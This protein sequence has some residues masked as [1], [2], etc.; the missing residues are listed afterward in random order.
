MRMGVLYLFVLCICTYSVSVVEGTIKG[1]PSSILPLRGVN[2]GNWFCPERWM[3][4]GPIFT[5]LDSS[6]QSESPTICQTLG[7]SAC[8]SRYNQLW[9]TF[10]TES[11]FSLMHNASINAIRLPISWWMIYDN[12]SP[13][14]TGGLAWIDKAM[15]WAQ[16]YKIGVIIDLHRVPGQGNWNAQP[17]YI[18][19]T[20]NVIT[21]LAT[22]YSSHPCLIGIDLFNEPGENWGNLRSYYLQAYNS[23]HSIN[24]NIAVIIMTYGASSYLN[25]QSGNMTNLWNEEHYYP[26]VFGY[27]NSDTH[28]GLI[29]LAGSEIPTQTN[30]YQNN[31]FKAP[32]YYGE[33]A[34]SNSA[35]DA[36]PTGFSRT[37]FKAVL[38][39][40][41]TAKVGWTFWAWK[42]SWGNQVGQE[43][44]WSF[45]SEIINGNIF[46]SDISDGGKLTF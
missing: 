26:G 36:T 31:N 38:N 9:S 4:E 42:T 2:L 5:G 37:Y 17:T 15:S 18:Q 23:I 22:R 6:I 34:L 10:I 16:K 32:L 1:G 44:P 20:L 46:A 30:T 35:S 21:F 39:A 11:D 40:M 25:I 14:P 28:Q 33:W 3:Q 29:N 13:Y 12:Q 45:Y 43:M 27:S 24:A 41:K 7:Q 19:Q 8:Q